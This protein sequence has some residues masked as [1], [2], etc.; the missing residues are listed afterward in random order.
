MLGD[1]PQRILNR[2]NLNTCNLATTVYNTWSDA[3]PSALRSTDNV[4]NR[5]KRSIMT[6]VVLGFN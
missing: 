3:H 6:G 2:L 5:L 1:E 4:Y